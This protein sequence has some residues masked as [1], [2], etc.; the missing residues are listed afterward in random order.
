MFNKNGYH[1]FFQKKNPA[2]RNMTNQPREQGMYPREFLVPNLSA[3]PT[4]H[5]HAPT[6]TTPLT[7]PEHPLSDPLRPPGSR[8]PSDSP[9]SPSSSS[10]ESG[11]PSPTDPSRHRHGCAPAEGAGAERF[12]GGLAFVCLRGF[13]PVALPDLVWAGRRGSRSP[14]R[15]RPPRRR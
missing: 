4:N 7:G 15:R 3:L 8:V 13:P 5:V 12:F 9:A 10:P 14:R 11:S 2:Q 1:F 6:C